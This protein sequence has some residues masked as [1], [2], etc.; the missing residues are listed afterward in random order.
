[1]DEGAQN[2][3][4]V[5]WVTQESWQRLACGGNATRGTVPAHASPSVRASVALYTQPV[6]NRAPDGYAV[7]LL[8]KNAPSGFWI[9]AAYVSLE[10]AQALAHKNGKCE[11]RPIHF[12]AALPQEAT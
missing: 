3:N 8:D 10:T 1:M 9:A 4:P 5:A 6:L 7:L 11:I 12:G 2:S